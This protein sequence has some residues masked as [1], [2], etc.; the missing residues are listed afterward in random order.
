MIDDEDN[1]NLI[2]LF[3]IEETETVKN[4][5]RADLI[6]LVAACFTQSKYI[7]QKSPDSPFPVVGLHFNKVLICL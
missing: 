3:F 6:W 2:V 1:V 4:A 5:E 7:I